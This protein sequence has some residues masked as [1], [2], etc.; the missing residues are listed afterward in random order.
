MQNSNVE[1]IIDDRTH[2]TIGRRLI[3]ARIT[4]YPIVVIVGKKSL[5]SQP[6]IEIYEVYDNITNTMKIESSVAFIKQLLDNYKNH[7]I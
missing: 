4:G 7:S 2:I 5:A 6:Q 3:D 1:S